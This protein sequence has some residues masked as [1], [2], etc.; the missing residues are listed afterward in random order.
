MIRVGVDRLTRG[1]RRRERGIQR[2]GHVLPRLLS[3]QRGWEPE[4]PAGPSSLPRSP[5]AID[6]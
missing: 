4:N 2:V 6:L 1:G 3:I 5:K